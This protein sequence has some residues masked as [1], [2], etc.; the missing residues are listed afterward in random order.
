M[1]PTNALYLAKREARFELFSD[2][3]WY[4][5]KACLI[6]LTFISRSP[7]TAWWM[8]VCLVTVQFDDLSIP[9]RCYGGRQIE[10][11]RSG[12]HSGVRMTG[13]W[14]LS[15]QSWSWSSGLGSGP[16]LSENFTRS[17]DWE[18]KETES[19][20]P[21]PAEARR[22][23]AEPGHTGLCA[24]LRTKKWLCS[25]LSS[26]STGLMADA[27]LTRLLKIQVRCLH[28]KQPSRG[29]GRAPRVAPDPTGGR[30]RLTLTTFLESQKMCLSCVPSSDSSSERTWEIII[31]RSDVRSHLDQRLLLPR[32]SRILMMM[33]LSKS[34][35]KLRF[36][37]D[38]FL[39]TV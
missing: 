9:R 29:R 18:L 24:G 3:H 17:G 30:L 14:R 4:W 36:Y 27:G 23:Q 8:Q 26:A 34:E 28:A 11:W 35:Y 10:D 15:L 38:F 12:A 33:S 1:I 20:E 2:G 31:L 37:G 7:L 22:G 32:I 21:E 19:D 5:D 6:L 25:A 39:M 16:A 13:Q